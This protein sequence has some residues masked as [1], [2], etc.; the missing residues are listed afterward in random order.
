MKKILLVLTGGTIG[1]SVTG[2]TIDT[3]ASARLSLMARLQDHYPHRHEFEFRT[4][5]PA[6][7]LSENLAPSV[8]EQI[9]RAM[10]AEGLTEFD[11][12]IITHGT[13]TLAFSAAALGLYWH[14]IGLPI[15]LVS[16]NYPIEDSR[17]NGIANLI[18]AL[19]FIRQ[20]QGTGVFVPYQNPGQTMRVHLGTRIASSLQLSGDFMSVQNKD[21]W[22]YDG[23]G[24]K[25]PDA[26]RADRQR[27]S[28]PLKACFAKGILMI[29]PYPGLDYGSFHLPGVKAVLHDLYHSGT[30]SST[31]D[32]GNQHS[33]PK[34][35]ERCKQQNIA[36]FLAPAIKNPVCYQSTKAALDEGARMIWNLSLEAAYAKL[37][38]A[39][40]N[41]NDLR[42]ISDFLDTDIA[43][44]HIQ[45]N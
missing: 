38:L 23:N 41:F 8:W 25:A 14:S 27:K 9:I 39:Y 30:A 11:G 5:R 34:F 24:F 35:I 42:M 45:A 31:R 26:L 22:V 1:S 4:I 20:L 19:E 37:L 43:H 32:Y 21:Y 44:E 18:C 3:D 12:A 7:L 2:S 10:E 13:D 36:V 17:A 15:L 33:L 40:G 28:F 29:R 6:E 16:S